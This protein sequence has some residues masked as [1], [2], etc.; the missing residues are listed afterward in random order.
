MI[1]KI[2]CEFCK[3]KFELLGMPSHLLAKHKM[4]FKDYKEKFLLEYHD[5]EICGKK[6]SNEKRFCSQRCAGIY[7]AKCVKK[8]KNRYNSGYD[9]MINMLD[10]DKIIKLYTVEKK[11]MI[12]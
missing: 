9:E 4:R 7:G 6:V 10:I 11:S 2:T 12:V 8:H 1:E 3:E 5:C